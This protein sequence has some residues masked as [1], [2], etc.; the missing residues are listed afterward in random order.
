MYRLSNKNQE[1]IT[2]REHMG[3]SLVVDGVRVVHLF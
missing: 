2:V 1:L 3:S